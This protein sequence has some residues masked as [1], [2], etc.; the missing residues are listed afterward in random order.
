ME[1]NTS[2]V[3]GGKVGTQVQQKL[4][5]TAAAKQ[6]YLLT[7]KNLLRPYSNRIFSVIQSLVSSF[8]VIHPFYLLSGAPCPLKWMH[9]RQAIIFKERLIDLLI[10]WLGEPS[11]LVEDLLH[12]DWGPCPLIIQK[13]FMFHPFSLVSYLQVE[14]PN[15]FCHMAKKVCSWGKI[16]YMV[17]HGLIRTGSDFDFQKFC[18]SGLDRMQIIW[19]STELGLKNFTVRSSPVW[20]G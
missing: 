13:L 4:I 2:T 9:S 11:I 16:K 6:T 14:N 10:L 3:W 19:I 7:T 17:L 5:T 15:E 18:R 20:C 8:S 1:Y 12:F